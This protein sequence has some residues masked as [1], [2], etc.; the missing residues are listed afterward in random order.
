[1]KSITIFILCAFFSFQ[2]IANNELLPQEFLLSDIE[3]QYVNELIYLNETVILDE[4]EFCLMVYKAFKS[5]RSVN[6]K[7]LLIIPNNQTYGVEYINGEMIKRDMSIS[8]QLFIDK[9]LKF[10]N[11]IGAEYKRTSPIYKKIQNEIE[12]E[13]ASKAT[14]N[15]Q[16]NPL[17]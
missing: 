9:V 17:K 13:K 1:M 2:S 11:K 3:E 6:A 5:C 10:F 12:N 8:E 4:I 7:F 15:S 16:E 14:S